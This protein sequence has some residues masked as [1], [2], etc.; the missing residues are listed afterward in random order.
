MSPSPTDIIRYYLYLQKLPFEM[1]S[2]DVLKYFSFNSSLNLYC[3]PSPYKKQLTP[4]NKNRVP[5]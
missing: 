1:G 3:P 5:F 2:L 4:M